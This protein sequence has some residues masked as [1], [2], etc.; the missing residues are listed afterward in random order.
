MLYDRCKEFNALPYSGGMVDQ[1]EHVMYLMATCLNVRRLH[2]VPYE[3]YGR[4][5]R[6]Q[7]DYIDYLRGAARGE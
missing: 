4:L 5:S 3:E 1:D 7:F 2:G 6:D